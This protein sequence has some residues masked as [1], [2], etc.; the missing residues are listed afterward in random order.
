MT[1]LAQVIQFPLRGYDPILT[2][3][4]AAE[5]LRCSIRSIERYTSEDYC[6]ARGVAVLPSFTTPFGERRFRL[7]EVDRW[8]E[9]KVA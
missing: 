6:A 9:G 8:N 4:E 7:S 2:K 3:R 5:R 1:E